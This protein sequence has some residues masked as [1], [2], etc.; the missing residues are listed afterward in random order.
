M[1]VLAASPVLP[2]IDYALLLDLL[3]QAGS[4]MHSASS[5]AGQADCACHMRTCTAV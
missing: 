1:R 2:Q 4:G 3:L 5:T